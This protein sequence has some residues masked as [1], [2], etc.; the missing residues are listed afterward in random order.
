MSAATIDRA[1]APC[2]ERSGGPRRS[3]SAGIPLVRRSIPVRTF[4]D[5]RD[6]PLGF[7]EADLVVHSG[8]SPRGSY[9]QTL[10][11]TDVAS[12]WTECAPLLVR[13]QHLLIEALKK[14]R[15]AL[16]FPLLGID[17]D[18]DMVFINEILKAY[19]E[20]TALP[21]QECYRS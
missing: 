21:Q 6:P 2:R 15:A 10:V 1:L 18:N 9:V 11:L 19:C 14:L 3:P 16:P 13:E 4:T 12:G 20:A 17:T 5:W 7:V 8:P